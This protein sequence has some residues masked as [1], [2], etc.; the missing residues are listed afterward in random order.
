M[1]SKTP[2][3]PRARKGYV[4]AFFSP[5]FNSSRIVKWTQVAPASAEAASVKSFS[6]LVSL[7]KTSTRVWLSN[8]RSPTGPPGLG[9]F[10]GWGTLQLEPPSLLWLSNIRGGG[11]LGRK[12][13]TASLFDSTATV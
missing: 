1:R 4:R 10:V 8:G 3:L 13:V 7:L 2:S 9:N 12:N 6:I 11:P 5:G